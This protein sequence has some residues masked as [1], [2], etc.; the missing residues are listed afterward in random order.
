MTMLDRNHRAPEP[1]RPTSKPTQEWSVL[2]RR[3]M[4]RWT[5]T[6]LWQSRPQPEGS[7]HSQSLDPLPLAPWQRPF[8]DIPVFPPSAPRSSDSTNGADAKQGLAGENAK[9]APVLMPPPVQRKATVSSSG[10]PYEREADEVADKVMR[11]AE[12]APVGSAPVGSAPVAIQR[13]CTACEEEDKEKIY[14]KRVPSTNPAASLDAVDVTR[15]TQQGGAPMPRDVRDFFEPRFGYDFGSVRI[16]H[17]SA[18]AESAQAIH[19]RAYT[20]GRDIVFARGQYSPETTDGRRLLAHELVHVRQQASGAGPSL[21]QRQPDKDHCGPI[22]AIAYNYRVAAQEGRMEDARKLLSQASKEDAAYLHCRLTA[23]GDELSKFARAKL[24]D[25]GLTVATNQLKRKLG[26]PEVPVPGADK[27]KLWGSPTAKDYELFFAEMAKGPDPDGFV[28]ESDGFI[29]YE[30]QPTY[31]QDNRRGW[32]KWVIFTYPDGSKMEVHLDAI[33]EDK[34]NQQRVKRIIER[35]WGEDLLRITQIS[36]DASMFVVSAATALKNP[37]GSPWIARGSPGMVRIPGLRG[38]LYDP[39]GSS[40]SAANDM[41][42]APVS[43]PEVPPNVVPLVRSSPPQV[44]GTLALDLF[45]QQNAFGAPLQDVTPFSFSRPAP[46]PQAVALDVPLTP[47][48]FYQVPGNPIAPPGWASGSTLPMGT[49]TSV[50]DPLIEAS[51]R[52]RQRQTAPEP[53]LTPFPEAEAEAEPQPELRRDPREECR[54]WNPYAINC[55]TGASNAES[56]VRRF[57]ASAGHANISRLSCSQNS[58]FTERDDIMACNGAPGMTYHCIP[59]GR[60]DLTVSVFGCQCCD[61]KGDTSY[62]WRGPHWSINLSKRG[63]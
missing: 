10:D 19:A 47:T 1:L 7:N 48:R 41:T 26:V 18:A 53:G 15:A 50:L 4:T 62:T 35:M 5:R 12:P 57:L 52:Q 38:N 31:K 40:A 36:A 2:S 8:L 11:M 44:S 58:T 3:G 20:F 24:S 43:G 13:K 61:A 30:Y 54:S 25:K 34:P 27:R 23:P 6:E 46:M 56:S 59:D 42:F 9:L 63:R 21:V 55:E 28:M 60:R 32:S 17:D 16:H 51:R 45:A 14:A 49:V 22:R 39:A 33:P 29:D 37:L